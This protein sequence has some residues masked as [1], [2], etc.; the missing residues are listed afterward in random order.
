[1]L[2]DKNYNTRNAFYYGLL[3]GSRVRVELKI[4]GFE[5]LKVLSTNLSFYALRPTEPI[6]MLIAYPDR[7]T[8]RRS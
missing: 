1:V 3:G 5:S 8:F 2:K 6:F 4:Q 7:N